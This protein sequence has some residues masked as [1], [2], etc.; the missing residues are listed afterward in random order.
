MSF[1]HPSKEITGTKSWVLKDKKIVLCVT[2]SVS[3][4]TSPD[5]ARELMRHGAEVY[6]VMSEAAKKII[7]P[8]TF[9]WAT[10]NPVVTELTGKVEHVAFTEKNGVDLVLIAPATA[11]T[12]SK[13]A[14]GICDTPLTTV[15]ATALGTGIPIMIVPA[16]HISLD[17]NPAV[18]ENVRKLKG[19]NVDF[20]SPR[21]E[22]GKAKIADK[23]EITKNVITRLTKT[24]DMEGMKVLITA[25][26][27]RSPFDA[28][29]YLTNPS[30][31]KMGLALGEEA[32]TRGADVTLVLG[33]GVPSPP[34]GFHVTKV[35]TTEEM[36]DVVI[37]KLKSEKYDIIVLSAAPLDFK[38]EKPLD[39]KV[40]SKIGEIKTK[41][42]LL[43]KISEEVRNIS[44]DIFYIGF[45]AEYNIS[46]EELIDRAYESLKE[47]GQNLIV[48]N[49]VAT[50]GAGFATDTN[51]VYVID[52]KKKAV[53][54]ALSPKIEVAK[55]IYDM[56][57]EKMKK[58]K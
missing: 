48:A 17:K 53:H 36:F 28:I 30:S 19:F 9:E 14:C 23:I 38:F 7:H 57:L 51:E 22:E 13:I 49:D 44:K 56:A 8:D 5:I 27:T 46:K 47:R 16:M 18:Q 10:G 24:K 12:I 3:A 25:G 39:Y 37:S 4:Y 15:I 50:E 45:K 52:E 31:G 34:S 32:C 1:S 42:I 55:R 11:N 58:R 26:P 54:I 40:S 6:V 35:V 2:S 29:R 33:P 41:L 20:I 21:Y 43:P